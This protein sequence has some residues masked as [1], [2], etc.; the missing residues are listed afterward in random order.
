MHISRRI[1]LERL[2]RSDTARAR[3]L[4]NRPR[5]A[6]LRSLRRVAAGLDA[7]ERRL[8]HRIRITSGYRSPELN[9]LVGGVGRSQHTRGEAV[10]FTCSSFGSPL[11]VARALL[12]S[13]IRFDQLIYEYGC[14]RDGGWV[15]LSFAPKP[16]RRTLT[17]CSGQRGY[18][19]GLHPCFSCS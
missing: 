2:T 3:R 18:R 17:I 16:R 4:S 10:D 19:A 11:E 5:F 13:D 15:H 14:R 9:R 8:G 6:A 7:V 12:G 1:S